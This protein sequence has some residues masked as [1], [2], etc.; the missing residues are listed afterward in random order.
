MIVIFTRE[1]LKQSARQTPID[2]ITSEHL[3]HDLYHTVLIDAYK[4]YFCDG[5]EVRCIK[6][7]GSSC[8]KTDASECQFDLNRFPFRAVLTRV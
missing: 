3:K 7:R 2:E 8:C 4:V 6:D 5:S 1:D